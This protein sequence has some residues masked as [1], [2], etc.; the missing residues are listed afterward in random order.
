MLA[1]VLLCAGGVA[2]F[3]ALIDPWWFF[4]H[5][6]PVNRVQKPFDEPAQKTNWLHAL[7]GRFEAVLFGSSRTAYIDQ[8]A[9]APYGM[10]NYAV[11]AMWPHEYRPYL[12]H[13]TAMNGRPPEL[14][15]PGV[16][17]VGTSDVP[18]DDHDRY[19]RS[20]ARFLS[21][22]VTKADRACAVLAD[23]ERS[24][25]RV[26]GPTYIYNPRL[27]TLWRAARSTQEARCG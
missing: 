16:D 25:E 13:F 27:P 23:L 11:N 17:F 24:S 15:V 6:H 19:D 26:F 7:P 22:A 8:N 5:A 18:I 9:F 2:G 1:V 21:D 12:D 4:A 3:N 10:L 20:N 14:V